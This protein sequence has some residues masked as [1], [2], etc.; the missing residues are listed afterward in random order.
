MQV[1]VNVAVLAFTKRCEVHVSASYECMYEDL[2]Q[3]NLFC[4]LTSNHPRSLC[5]TYVE[6]QF[7]LKHQTYSLQKYKHMFNPDLCMFQQNILEQL[8]LF[9]CVINIGSGFQENYGFHLR[10]QRVELYQLLHCS[11]CWKSQKIL[12]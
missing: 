7:C 11:L 8:Y 2:V 12:K 9:Q 1:G 10:F 6:V 4:V 3:F 5:T